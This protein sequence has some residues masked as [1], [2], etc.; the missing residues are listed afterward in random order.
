MLAGSRAHVDQPVGA[1]HG[2]QV[3]FHHK[4]RIACGF[5][6][7]KRSEQCFAIRRVQ[8][9]RR[10][11]EHINNAEQLRA[12]LGGQAQTLQLPGRQGRRAALQG[13]ITQAQ[14]DQGVDPFEQVLGDA[15]GRQA[16]F[17]RQLHR[18]VPR[19]HRLQQLG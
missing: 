10:L 15:L 4:Q 6:A 5:Q 12:Q 18:V 9:R 8:T 17:H 1:A 11:I 3:M 16:F 2:F 14:L 13:Q 19:G 7:I